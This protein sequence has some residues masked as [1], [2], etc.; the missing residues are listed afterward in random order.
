[1]DAAMRKASSYDRNKSFVD[2]RASK[3]VSEQLSR[4]GSVNDALGKDISN[5][6]FWLAA[7]GLF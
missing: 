5:W 2:K 7:E 6:L 3:V 1:M 4:A